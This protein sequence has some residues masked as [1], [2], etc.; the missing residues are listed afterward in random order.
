M[1]TKNKILDYFSLLKKRGLIGKSYLFIGEDFS[2]VKDIA[3]LINCKEDK[4]YFCSNCWDCSSIESSNHPDIFTLKSETLTI[5]IENIK[6]A[7][8][9]LRLK[10]FRAQKKVLVIHDAQNMGEASANAFLKTL[11]EPPKN[12]FI[13]I[14]ASRIDSLIPT[15]ISRCNKVFFPFKEDKTEDFSL[16]QVLGFLKGERPYFKDRKDFLSFI[17][18]LNLVIRDVFLVSLGRN[19]QLLGRSDCEIILK[20][21]KIK[22][23]G[24]YCQVI[25]DILEIYSNGATINENLALNLIR[26]RIL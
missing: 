20:N 4:C 18:S 13:A 25:R 12:S 15:I 16:P 24:N 22:N 26:E 21:I 3:K 1:Q 9:F 6:E 14:C 17:W 10:S 23:T 19:N 8:Q 11:E 5:T 7:Q 2:L